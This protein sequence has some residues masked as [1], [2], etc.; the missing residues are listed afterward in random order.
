MTLDWNHRSSYDA[1]LEAFIDRM[2]AKPADIKW[3]QT[4]K[5]VAEIDRLRAIGT[6]VENENVALH[7]EVDRLRAAEPGWQALLENERAVVCDLMDTV[8]HLQAENA[9]LRGQQCAC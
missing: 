4:A 1:N 9:R 7:A 2:R 3:D 5:L 8:N 6:A